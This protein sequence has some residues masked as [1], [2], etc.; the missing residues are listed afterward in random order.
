MSYLLE[1]LPRLDPDE[2]NDDF[3]ADLDEGYFDI[4]T[5][6]GPSS[7]EMTELEELR[8]WGEWTEY[9]KKYGWY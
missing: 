4:V 5:T 2:L 6:T 8:K 7:L 9:Q 3:F 1:L